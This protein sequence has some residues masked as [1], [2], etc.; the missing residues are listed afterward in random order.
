MG[1]GQLGRGKKPN[2]AC[3]FER[4][5]AVLKHARRQVGHGIGRDI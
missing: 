4:G 2:W 1:E 3:V 5:H